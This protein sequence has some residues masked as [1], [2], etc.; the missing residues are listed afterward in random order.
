MNNVLA[1]THT[2]SVRADR[3]TELGGHQQHG[4]DLAHAG[5]ADGVDLAD[6]DGFGLEELLEDHP[7]V[8]VLTGRDAD[9]IRL[10]SLSDGGVTENIIWSSRFLDEPGV[11]VRET[12]QSFDQSTAYQGLISASPLVY[13]IAWLTSHT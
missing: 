6:V 3:D 10:E 11:K 9:P 8:C 7:V 5:K 4:E 2:S 13:S 1:Q 12:M